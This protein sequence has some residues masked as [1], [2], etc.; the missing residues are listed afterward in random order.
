MTTV[1][2]VHGLWIHSSAWR[3]WQNLFESAGYDTQAPGWPGDGPTVE[4]TRAHPERLAGVGVA[5]IT[6]HYAAIASSLNE[7]PIII[8]HSFGGLVAQKLLAAGIAQAAVAIDPAPIKGVRALPF[9]QIRSA[10]P[11]VSRKANADRTV[12][13]NPR[14]FRYGF[15]NAI[16]R[17]ESDQL[18]R[19]YTIPG[20]GRPVF[21][22]TGAKKDTASP[23]EVALDDVRRGPLLVMGGSRDHTIPEVV[24]RQAALLYKPGSN[25][26]YRRVEGRGHSLV[27]DSGWETVAKTALEWVRRTESSVT[28]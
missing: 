25:T 22:L 4:E 20:P 17:T 23:T 16:S 15:G 26:V 14:Q 7:K 18:H 21:E 10:L 9:A 3:P 12:A 28:R 24:A 6:N 1:L 19:R 27:F 2:F 13:L 11:V 8:G 5:E